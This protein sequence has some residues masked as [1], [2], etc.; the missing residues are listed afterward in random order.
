MISTERKAKLYENL[1]SHLVNAVDGEDLY[2]VLRN[3]GFT[4]KEIKKEEIDVPIPDTVNLISDKSISALPLAKVNTSFGIVYVEIQPGKDEKLRVYDS[5]GRYMGYYEE[6]TF[7]NEAEKNNF[8]FEDAVFDF[9]YVLAESEHLGDLLT[10]LGD[11]GFAS[12]SKSEI[13]KKL[14]LSVGCTEKE[15]LENEYVNKIGDT[16]VVFDD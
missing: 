11:D 8:S 6:E 15:L 2:L 13:A 16:Y 12:S 4:V 9:C 10:Q 14:G 7:I 5:L 3:I 1:L